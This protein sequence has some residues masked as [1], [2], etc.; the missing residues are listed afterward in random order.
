MPFKLVSQNS[1]DLKMLDCLS[2]QQ[3]GVFDKFNDLDNLDNEFCLK[4]TGWSKIDFVKFCNLITSVNE[5]SG[6][7]KEQLIALYRYWLRKGV[8]QT[9]L[10]LMFSNNT[11]QNQI[12]HYLDQI[13]V[14][15]NKDFVPFFLGTKN[16]KSFFLAH[17]TITAVE[18]HDISPKI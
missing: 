13:R 3:S 7:S 1:H 15:I 18:L 8:D 4:I 10:A 6:R 11:T 14:A 9:T 17:N 16:G 12:S 2:F 5:T